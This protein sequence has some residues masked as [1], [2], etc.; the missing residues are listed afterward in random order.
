MSA[1]KAHVEVNVVNMSGITLSEDDKIVTYEEQI[2]MTPT[3][4]HRSLKSLSKG[5]QWYQ[6]WVQ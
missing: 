5:G 2:K 3:L 4:D 6:H 1:T